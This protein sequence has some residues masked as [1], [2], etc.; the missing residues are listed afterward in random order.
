LSNHTAV[1]I[2]LSRLFKC[3][4]TVSTTYYNTRVLKTDENASDIELLRQI[5]LLSP[6]IRDTFQL[7]S[8]FRQFLNT[9]LSTERLFAIG[10]NVGGYFARLEKLVAEHSLAIQDG[11]DVAAE[12]YEMEIREAIS[13][14]ADSIDDELTILHAMVATKFAAV[15]TIA[16]K[17]RQNLHYQDRTSKLVILLENFHFAEFADQL[18]GNEDLALSFRALLED[19]IPT[20]REKLKAVLQQLQQYLFEFRKIE[21]RARLVRSFALHLN[22]NPDWTPKNWDDVASPPEWVGLAAPMALASYPDV[23]QPAS[24]DLLREIAATIPASA[25]MRIERRPP[26]Q[27]VEE[28]TESV[29]VVAQSPLKKAVRAFFTEATE[30]PEWISA[31]HWWIEHPAM[32][33]SIGEDVWLLRLVSE[34]ER[35]GRAGLWSF[36][37]VEHPHPV[38]DGNVLIQDVLAARKGL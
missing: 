38:F 7:R 2:F 23:T 16:E 9:A 17:R 24:E 10:A 6:D 3:A 14:I 19:R 31:R 1:E 20:F 8:S 5:R 33:S 29:V 21:D 37:R 36:R 26:G 27:L 13:D 22:R 15:S 30:S 12:Q 11:R 35:E 32:T 34:D 18:A 25:E 4:G 28:L